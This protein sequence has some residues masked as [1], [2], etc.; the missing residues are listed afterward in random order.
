MSVSHT[1]QPRPVVMVKRCLD[2]IIAGTPFNL[3]TVGRKLNQLPYIDHY[4]RISEDYQHLSDIIQ[5]HINNNIPL[6]HSIIRSPNNLLTI[7]V[8]AAR[9][10]DGTYTPLTYNGVTLFN[11]N[12]SF[13]IKKDL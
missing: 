3:T 1:T 10:N 4:L 2:E 6:D 5:D 9:N 11:K 8:H 12:M 13:Y 7:R